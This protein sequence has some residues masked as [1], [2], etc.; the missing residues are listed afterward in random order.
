MT[1]FLVSIE[2]LQHKTYFCRQL[3]TRQCLGVVCYRALC[4]NFDH[5]VASFVACDF[6]LFSLLLVYYLGVTTSLR[7]SCIGDLCFLDRNNYLHGVLSAL[8]FGWIL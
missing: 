8:K 1:S 5:I 3:V 2:W 4:W 6:Q 7:M